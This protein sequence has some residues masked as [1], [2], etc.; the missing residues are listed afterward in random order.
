MGEYDLR[1]PME[2]RPMDEELQATLSSPA[3]RT[4]TPCVLPAVAPVQS[5]V[6]SDLA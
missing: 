1:A 3:V 6:C 4:D 5:K 2:R